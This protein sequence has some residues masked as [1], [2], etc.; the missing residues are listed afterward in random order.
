MQ[1]TA[2]PAAPD[3]RLDKAR[4]CRLWRRVAVLDLNDAHAHANAAHA[5]DG[6]ETIFAELDAYY[7]EAHRFYHTGGHINDCLMRMDLA[8]D[9]LGQSDAVE[10][11]VWFH[12]VIYQPG[13]ADNEQR[14]ADWFAAKAA[15]HL[16]RELVREVAGYIMDTT[17]REPPHE[18]GGQFVVDVDLSGLG[19]DE[20]PFWRDGENIRKEAADLSDAEFARRQGGFLRMLLA[21]ERIFSTPFFYDLCETCARENIQAA[22]DYYQ[23]LLA[24]D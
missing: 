23:T 21:R 3:T 5:D 24:A 14:S 11:A 2:M 13:Q 15:P 4:F 8:A 16:P 20:K 7:R 10:L 22:L 17:H 12:D 9:S 1:P 6:G 19:M 18:A